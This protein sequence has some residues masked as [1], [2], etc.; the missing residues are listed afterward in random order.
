MNQIIINAVMFLVV[1]FSGTYRI[2]NTLFSKNNAI[3]NTITEC[4]THI[5][6]ILHTAL[7]FLLTLGIQMIMEKELDI[8]NTLLTTLVYYFISDKE[9]YQSSG[10]IFNDLA[11][12]NG[13]PTTLGMLIHSIIYSLSMYGISK[14]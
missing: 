11:D 3:Y 9:I 14:L 13:C 6:H 2:T 10:F 7:L 4:P 1:S 12:V 8:T 5:G